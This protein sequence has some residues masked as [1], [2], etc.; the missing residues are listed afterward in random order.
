MTTRYIKDPDGKFHGS[1][2]DGRDT[3]PTGARVTVD[4]TP[5]TADTP[6]TDLGGVLAALKP[7]P[8]VKLTFEQKMENAQNNLL[9]AIDALRS[10]DDW[11]AA[12]DFAASV[13]GYSFG[14]SMLLAFEHRMR[15]ALDPDNVPAEPGYFM[16]FNHWKDKGRSVLKGAKGYPILAPNLVKSRYYV[17]NTGARIY[18]K[19]GDK[20]PAGRQVQTTQFLKGF[21]VTYTFAQCDTDGEPVPEMPRPTLLAGETLPGLREKVIELAEADGYTVEYINRA[22][23]PVLAGGANGYTQ[24]ATKR[25]VVAADLPS[26]FQKDKTLIHEFGHMML[27]AEGADGHSEHHGMK[28]VQAEA[29]AY[30]T[31]KT[32]ADFDT[33]DYSVAY[34]TGWLAAVPGGKEEQLKEAQRAL[35][36]VG[37]VSKRIIDAYEQVPA[38]AESASA[39]TVAA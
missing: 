30:L 24:W 31:F 3:V 22:D 15:H 17:D 11:K 4:P 29:A 6:D 13:R 38:D 27:H 28:E 18:L 7:V 9:S 16:S 21:T 32:L 14:N 36:A 2:G 39:P 8:P 1:I 34:T 12:L 26:E 33:S 37:K 20:V 23:D 25:I 35:N 19:K 10:S 5:G